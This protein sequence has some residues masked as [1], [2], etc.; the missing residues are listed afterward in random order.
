MLRKL[1]QF[2]IWI[3]G[4][5][6]VGHPVPVPKIV[7]IVAYHTS[8]WDGVTTLAFNIALKAKVSWV[9]KASIFWWPLGSFLRSVGGI[10]LRRNSSEEFVN[11]MVEQFKIRDYFALGMA[12]EGTRKRAHRW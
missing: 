12:P 2:C 10:P 8:N 1:A 9:G 7:L 3:T 6:A 11:Q 4:W 5:K